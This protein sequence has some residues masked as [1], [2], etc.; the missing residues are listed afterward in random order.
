MDSG[1]ASYEPQTP[2]LAP[3]RSSADGPTDERLPGGP[4]GRAQR[5]MAQ[6][7]ASQ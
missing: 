5:R 2:E 3:G 6:D 7:G 1:V 4:G